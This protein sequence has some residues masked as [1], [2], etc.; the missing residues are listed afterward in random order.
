MKTYK[1]KNYKKYSRKNRRNFGEF[2]DHVRSLTRMPRNVYK[3]IK[4]TASFIVDEGQEI[5]NM[6]KPA[7][8]IRKIVRKINDENTYYGYNKIKGWKKINKLYFLLKENGILNC[9]FDKSPYEICSEAE[10]MNLLK[11]MSELTGADIKKLKMIA[12]IRDTAKIK[13]EYE[14]KIKKEEDELN[15]YLS[16]YS[17]VNND[18]INSRSKLIGSLGSGSQMG[19]QMGSPFSTR[20]GKSRR[21]RKFSRKF[22]REGLP[23]WEFIKNSLDAV[24]MGNSV[25]C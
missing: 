12:S 13:S 14:K 19:S 11:K 4:K 8:A 18:L 25:D 10:M 23:T 17:L 3:N 20:F 24:A 7:D 21:H 9:G 2:A 16:E 6:Y 15:N 22:G 1:R 5:I